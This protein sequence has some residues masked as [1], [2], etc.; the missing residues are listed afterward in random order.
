MLDK[1]DLATIPILY[2]PIL[3][4]IL[5][6]P[7]H[8]LRRA[9]LPVIAKITKATNDEPV[10]ADVRVSLARSAF[11]FQSAPLRRGLIIPANLP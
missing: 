1:F 6:G 10:Q 3:M 7:Q 9:W 11:N 8:P 5:M 4:P 2:M